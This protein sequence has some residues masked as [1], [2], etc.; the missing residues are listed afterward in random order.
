MEVITYIWQRKGSIGFKIKGL[1][2]L[3]LVSFYGAKAILEAGCADSQ[4]EVIN[5][6]DFKRPR[7]IL[8]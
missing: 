8:S 1:I 3:R 7:E 5:I 4:T 2:N 6:A